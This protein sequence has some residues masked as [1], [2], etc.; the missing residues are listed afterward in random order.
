MDFARRHKAEQAK[1]ASLR[2]AGQRTR[3]VETMYILDLTLDK[4]SADIPV[5]KVPWGRFEEVLK[6]MNLEA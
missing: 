3:Y 6:Q 5:K 2:Q 1:I 4:Q